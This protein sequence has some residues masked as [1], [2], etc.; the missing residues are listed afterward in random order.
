MIINSTVEG[1]FYASEATTSG[2]IAFLTGTT[3]ITDSTVSSST[4]DNSIISTSTIV[5]SNLTRCTVLNS[6]VGNFT[7]TD[8]FIDPSYVENSQGNFAS[9]TDSTIIDSNYDYSNI[10]L[11]TVLNSTVNYSTVTYSY[12]AT[13]TVL[14]SVS[15]YSTST[16]SNIS[17]STINNSTFDN[18]NISLS[19]VATSTINNSTVLNSD[20][21]LSTIASSTIDNGSVIS[22]SDISLSDVSNSNIT[23]SILLNS[24]STDSTIVDS[25]LDNSIIVNSTSTNST[26]TDSYI[27]SSTITNSVITNSTTTDSFVTNSTTTDSTIASSTLTNVTA[28][29]STI[30][31]STIYDVILVGAVILNDVMS[32]GTITY[33]GT[34]TVIS[35]STPLAA[36]INYAPVAGFSVATST[37]QVT[38]TDTSTDVNEGTGFVD[39]WTYDWSFGDGAT[40]TIATSSTNGSTLYTYA[41]SGTYT[42]DLIIT[43][44]YGATSSASTSVTVLSA[45]DLTAPVITLLGSNPVTVVASSTY[46]DAGATALDN[47][48]GNITGSIVTINPVDANT[49]GAYTVTYTVSDAALNSATATRTVNVVAT[50]DITDPIITILGSNPVN[51]TVGGIYTDLGATST[52]DVDG[53]ITANIITVGLPI[54]T[55]ATGT[56]NV[57]YSVTDGAGNSTSS[58]RVVNIIDVP[59]D[60]VPPVITMNGGTPITITVGSS[61]I[62]AGATAYD[63]VSGTTT[64]T[65]IF[66]DVNTSATGT[67]SIVYSSIDAALNAATTSRTINVIPTAQDNIAPVITITGGT[68]TTIVVGGTYTD[69]GA[70]ALDNVDGVVTA[71]T[72]SNNVDPLT[73]GTYTVAYSAI[74]AALNN[75]TAV[76]DVNVV[77]ASSSDIISPA[78]TITG[79]TPIT[80]IVGGSY[81]DA[82][83]TAL[84]D[85]DGVVS[86]TTTSNDVDPL[87]IGSYTVVYS[88]SDIAGN[89]SSATRNVNVVAAPPDITPPV[90]TMN[91]GTPITIALNLVYTDLGATAFDNVDATTTVNIIFNDVNTAATGTYTVVYSS[92]DAALNTATTSRTVNVI[93]DAVAPAVTVLGANPMTIIKTIAY[94]E[95]GATAVDNIDATTTVVISGS[96]NVNATGTYFMVYTATDSSGNS[97]SS[98]RTVNVIEDNIAPVITILGSNPDSLIVGGTY[99]DAG[100]T[101]LDNI[102]G[103]V[104][105]TT[106]ANNVDVNVVGTYTV[107]YS[108]TDAMGNVAT[109][110]RTVNVN[111]VDVIPPVIT[112]LGSNPV[113]VLLSAAYTDAG[114]TALD[115]VNGNV[116]GSIITTNL[117][118]TA[119]TGTYTVTYVVSDAQLNTSTS[120]RVVNVVAV[121]DITLPVITIL[122]S[123]PDSL[124]VGGVYTD[125]GATA[126]DD[127][128]GNITSNITLVSTVNT[129]IAG[130]Y[131]VVYTVIDG[132]G[133]SASST[134]IVNVNNPPTPPSGG[135]GGGSIVQVY[136]IGDLNRDGKI[137]EYDFSIMMSQWGQILSNLS[138]DLNRDGRVDEY[139][140]SILFSNWR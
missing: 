84:D 89:I 61:Y 75:A 34:T 47:I 2:A 38:L 126:T 25:N 48:D 125:V 118:N 127:V 70:T 9:S 43:D 50:A 86:A 67:Y 26:S 134:R 64:V 62:D 27:A 99:T 102:D 110:S 133:N 42:I 44:S 46:T 37:L 131:S 57:T 129:A 130:A 80:L 19:T 32:T 132:A 35:T 100:A 76:R 138:S 39:S 137:D 65:E 72:T 122:G 88:A 83:A 14:N 105:A 49:P 8:C 77:A 98:T 18:S 81:T 30:T 120:T 63:A 45:P 78:I 4:L 123:N 33:N 1:T 87:T 119:A 15:N 124:L 21:S 3:T 51:V 11:S 113:T 94:I 108:A 136:A 106:T 96:V 54:N 112:I 69:A 140:F 111:P 115:N 6:F 116:T 10:V 20:V 23:D 5:S 12:V 71:T 101:A 121:P 82:G 90:I 97:A 117:V 95:G 135:G 22:G 104:S 128:D 24:T 103:V 139:D 58:I 114:A 56:Q 92:T 16:F 79:G 85:V 7:G 29:S 55:A 53:D 41:G 40:S 73:I 31:N 107:D 93:L 36:L 59:V 13:S 52:D 17:T 68:P 60:T 109:S 91:G 66:N 28:S 74:D